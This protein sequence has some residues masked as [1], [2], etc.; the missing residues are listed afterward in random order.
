M[1]LLLEEEWVCSVFVPTMGRVWERCLGLLMGFELLGRGVG[2]WGCGVE[3]GVLGGIVG[4]A[5]VVV[6]GRGSRGR[7]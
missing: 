5:A 2:D 6:R 7:W 1:L 3:M 4:L